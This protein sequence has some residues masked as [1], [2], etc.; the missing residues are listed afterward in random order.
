VAFLCSEPAAFVSGIAFGV[1]GA[2]VAGLL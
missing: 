1:D 2:A